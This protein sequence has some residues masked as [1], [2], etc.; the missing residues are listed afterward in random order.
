MPKRGAELE[1]RGAVF[2]QDVEQLRPER[3]ER[4]LD[5]AG[6]SRRTDRRRR[7]GRRGSSERGVEMRAYGSRVR[8]ADHSRR[9][10]VD[11]LRLRA[12][13]GNSDERTHGRV[14]ARVLPRVA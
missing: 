1:R 5:V 2:G 13:G 11:L 6:R 14:L 3:G 10:L 9:D 7:R 8:L 12:D 4:A